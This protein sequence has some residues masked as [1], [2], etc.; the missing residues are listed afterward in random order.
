VVRETSDGKLKNT[1]PVFTHYVGENGCRVSSQV[2]LLAN[3]SSACQWPPTAVPDLLGQL[4][5]CMCT[6][7][8]HRRAA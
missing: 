5:P 1:F 6:P 4:G 2:P 3:D 8:R 7:R